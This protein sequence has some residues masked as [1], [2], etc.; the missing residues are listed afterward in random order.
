MIMQNK[1]HSKIISIFTDFCS[2]VFSINL[3]LRG[4]HD[5]FDLFYV[6]KPYNLIE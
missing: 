4:Y 3:S 2:L 1:P 6:K 5:S